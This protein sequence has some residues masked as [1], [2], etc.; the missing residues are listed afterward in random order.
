V[1]AEKNFPLNPSLNLS[2]PFFG[3]APVMT[4]VPAEGNRRFPRTNAMCAHRES[5]YEGSEWVYEVKLDEAIAVN[6]ENRVSLFSAEVVQQ[7]ISVYL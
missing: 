5:L 7:P 3:D 2:L 4:G 6:A 1:T